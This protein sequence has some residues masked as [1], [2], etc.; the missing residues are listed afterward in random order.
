MSES[1]SLCLV[2][3]IWLIIWGAPFL[4]GW[5]ILRRKKPCGFLIF[6]CAL[7]LSYFYFYGSSVLRM[8]HNDDMPGSIHI[9][10]AFMFSVEKNFG[11]K[12]WYDWCQKHIAESNQGE[13]ISGRLE[14]VPFKYHYIVVNK[15]S[16]LM[17]FYITRGNDGALSAE[18]KSPDKVFQRF[19]G[20]DEERFYKSI[21]NRDFCVAID[22]YV[23]ERRIDTSL[24]FYKKV[25]A[26]LILLMCSLTWLF[27]LAAVACKMRR[28]WLFGGMWCV[29][30]A[31]YFMNLFNWS[32]QTPALQF[33]CCDP[34]DAI[35]VLAQSE[36]Q[37]A[38]TK[39][40]SHPTA[41]LIDDKSKTIIDAPLLCSGDFFSA[42]F[43]CWD[44]GKENYLYY[45]P[46]DLIKSHLITGNAQIYQPAADF[47][48]V[49]YPEFV[50]VSNN[51]W[52]QFA[53]IQTIAGLLW[54]SMFI[55]SL[56]KRRET[57]ATVAGE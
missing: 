56:K 13:D 42:R 29:A 32:Q 24:Q 7:F 31:L 37:P 41:L 2:I 19:A 47:Y 44:L 1:L 12:N 5:W 27:P 30:G 3:I 14:S 15:A 35:A 23:W 43:L 39:L 17:R 57:A 33:E 38:L 9:N 28:R 36:N 26:F 8:I 4:A 55:L 11:L 20:Y 25:F 48:L 40:L 22:R 49:S 21:W 16:A 51:K 45:S 18:V 34:R 52:R 50:R 54:L 46:T 10:E 6:S 53:A